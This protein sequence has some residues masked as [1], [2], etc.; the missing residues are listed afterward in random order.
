[1]LTVK[2]QPGESNSPH[3]HSAHTFVYALEGSIMMQVKSEKEKVLNS[4][5]TFYET[6]AE[7]HTVMK[8]V[9]N[10]K[11]RQISCVFY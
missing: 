3:K 9:N 2:L 11:R 8:N 1:M 7:I 4:G 10:T 6:P 5:D